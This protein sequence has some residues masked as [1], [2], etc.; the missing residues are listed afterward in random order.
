MAGCHHGGV[1]PRTAPSL[2]LEVSAMTT[3]ERIVLPM[4]EDADSPRVEG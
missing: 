1:A 2:S 3:T 4:A